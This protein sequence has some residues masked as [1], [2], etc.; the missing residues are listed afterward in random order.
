LSNKSLLGEAIYGG[1]DWAFQCWDARKG[2]AC[3]ERFINCRKLCSELLNLAGILKLLVS[4]D[5]GAWKHR[6]LRLAQAEKLSSNPYLTL[7][8]ILAERSQKSP[9]CML[10][11][12]KKATLEAR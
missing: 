1:V 7:S 10:S 11:N 3:G 2:H 4:R 12:F 5:V 6:K 8:V 9:N